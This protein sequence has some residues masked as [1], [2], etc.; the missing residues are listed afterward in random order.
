MSR[1]SGSKWIFFKGAGGE[2]SA[3]PKKLAK[4]RMMPGNGT[5]CRAWLGKIGMDKYFKRIF[6]EIHT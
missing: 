1:A 3:L 4:L 6:L 5:R 2:R